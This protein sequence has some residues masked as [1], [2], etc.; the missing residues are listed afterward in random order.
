MLKGDVRCD[1]VMQ[2]FSKIKLDRYL[3]HL[4]K[5]RQAYKLLM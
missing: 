1:R 3:D 5:K 4:P 2:R